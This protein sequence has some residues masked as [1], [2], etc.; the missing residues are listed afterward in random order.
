VKDLLDAYL[1]STAEFLAMLK[2]RTPGE[3]AYD[4]EVVAGLRTGLSITKALELAGKKFPNEALQWDEK[5]IVEI[6][7][8]YEYLMNHEDILTKRKGLS[9]RR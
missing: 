4:T 6:K 3:V 5:S 7:D 8:H 9:P 2:E 1:E